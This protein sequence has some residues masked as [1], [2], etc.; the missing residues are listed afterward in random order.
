MFNRTVQAEPSPTLG[1][2]FTTELYL[3]LSSACFYMCEIKASTNSLS[4]TCISLEIT[5]F[6]YKITER[7][8]VCLALFTNCS[9]S[10]CR[11]IVDS[12]F[13]ASRATVEMDY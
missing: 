11:A 7:F 5:G 6:I 12:S 2:C 10:S 13:I 3:Q 8:E 9:E 4:L 1:K